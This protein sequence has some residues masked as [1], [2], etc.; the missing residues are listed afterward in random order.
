MTEQTQTEVKHLSTVELEAG[1]DLIQQS[2]KD[3]GLLQVLVRRPQS[4]ERELLQAGELDSEV[5][6]VGDNWQTRGSSLTA[7]RS[8]HPGMQLTI[9]NSRA[10]QLVAQSQDR[11]TLAGDQMFIDMDISMD[12]LPPGSQLALGSAVIEVTEVPHTGCAKFVARFGA[13]AM[14]FVNSPVG[15]ALRLRGVNLKVVQPGTIRVGDVAK[16]I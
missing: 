15:K 9:M 16:K 11:W 5:G 7:D 3:A 10:A 1:L 6:L 13:E 14:K 8:A 2:P 4:G 12:N